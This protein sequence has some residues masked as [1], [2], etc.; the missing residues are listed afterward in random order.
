MNSYSILRKN[1]KRRKF[2]FFQKIEPGDFFSQKVE[3][4]QPVSRV[5]KQPV[6]TTTIWGWF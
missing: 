3:T 2:F 5:R 1:T 4:D 6:Y